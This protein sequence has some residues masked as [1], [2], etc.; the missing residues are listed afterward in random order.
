MIIVNSKFL[1][2]IISRGFYI[3]NLYPL[4]IT[5]VPTKPKCIILPIIDAP[6]CTFVYR[7][8]QSVY[9]KY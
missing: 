5:N 4:F 1:Y 6:V 7:V 2:N 9:D 3:F 8:C